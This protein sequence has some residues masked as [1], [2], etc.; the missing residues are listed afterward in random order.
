MQTELDRIRAYSQTMSQELAEATQNESHYKELYEQSLHQLEDY[1]NRIIELEN[2]RR[3]GTR[4]TTRRSRRLRRTVDQSPIQS[5][6]QFLHE[7]SDGQT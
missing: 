2:S 3:L 1:R 4:G 7:A 5:S 6:S